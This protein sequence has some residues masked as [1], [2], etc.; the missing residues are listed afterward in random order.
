[1]AEQ[2]AFSGFPDQLSLSFFSGGPL[3]C[4]CPQIC[5]WACEGKELSALAVSGFSGHSYTRSQNLGTFSGE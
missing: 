2:L 5:L 3:S 4:P 1:M